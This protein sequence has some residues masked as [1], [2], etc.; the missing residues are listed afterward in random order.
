MILSDWTYLLM[1]TLNNSVAS[2]AQSESNVRPSWFAH[3]FARIC[4][5]L[6]HHKVEGHCPK[7]D[8]P[9][10]RYHE[11]EVVIPRTVRSTTFIRCVNADCK[12]SKK[13]PFPVKQQRREFSRIH[14]IY[15]Q[16]VQRHYPNNFFP[17]E[18]EK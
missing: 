17:K 16:L 10:F 15:F 6:S 4:G 8:K 13:P 1:E 14:W 2:R 18:K 12:A 9:V 7:C 11:S 3:Q 5:Y